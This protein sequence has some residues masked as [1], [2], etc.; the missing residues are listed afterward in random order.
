[1]NSLLIFTQSSISFAASIGVLHYRQRCSNNT[2]AEEEYAACVSK[3]ST[4]EQEAIQEATSAKAIE[5]HK[6]NC[7]SKASTPE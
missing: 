7:M 4:P 6:L 3:A 5:A 1:M 2:N